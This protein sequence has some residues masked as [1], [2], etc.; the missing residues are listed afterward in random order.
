[1]FKEEPAGVPNAKAQD[2]FRNERTGSSRSFS[3]PPTSGAKALNN[4]D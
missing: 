2:L 3:F 4:Y 1:M